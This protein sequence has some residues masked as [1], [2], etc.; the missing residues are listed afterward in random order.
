[1]ANIRRE[2]EVRARGWIKSKRTA[3][4]VVGDLA[5]WASV[6]MGDK[7]LDEAA[8]EFWAEVHRALDVLG[9]STTERSLFLHEDRWA[10]IPQELQDRYYRPTPPKARPLLTIGER[11][12]VER[13]MAQKGF[14]ARDTGGGF[15]AWE[16]PV[17]HKFFMRIT[18]GEDRL[19]DRPQEHIW[20]VG[21]WDTESGWPFD[22]MHTP[23]DKPLGI[24][25]L[26]DEAIGYGPMPLKSALDHEPVMRKWVEAQASMGAG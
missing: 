7:P 16:K 4:T 24:V 14:E 18:A 17:G 23:D 5:D 25:G 13:L 1:M 15:Y 10:S 6:T 9:M 22:V 2:A 3:I 26:D 11:A 19:H 20:L 12:K 21:L 8:T